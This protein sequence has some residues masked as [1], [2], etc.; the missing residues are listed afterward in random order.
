MTNLEK[1]QTTNIEEMVD[2]FEEFGEDGKFQDWYCKNKCPKRHTDGKCYEEE[3]TDTT[4]TRDCIRA[5]LE[6]NVK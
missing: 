1:I 2:I 5:Y 6:G 4:S 3:C